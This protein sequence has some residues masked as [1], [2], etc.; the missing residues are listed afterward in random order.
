MTRTADN[1]LT[2]PEPAGDFDPRAE[3]RAL[4]GRL[5][6]AYADDPANAA[7]A[8]ELRLTLLAIEPEEAEDPFD[9]IR[10]IQ[11]AEWDSRQKERE[12]DGR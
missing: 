2:V 6:V 8:R 10:M 3:L 11:R 12:Q 5:A 9:P 7:I 4:A 1:R